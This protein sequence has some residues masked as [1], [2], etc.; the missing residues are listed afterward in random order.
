V[1][2]LKESI[3]GDIENNL[4]DYEKHINSEMKMLNKTLSV[5]KNYDNLRSH[6]KY[7][8][9]KKHCRFIELHIPELLKLIGYD[10][11]YIKI[12]FYDHEDFESDEKDDFYWVI[13]I[14]I[15]KQPARK[16]Q[17]TSSIVYDYI[18]YGSSNL[19][20]KPIDI[21]KKLFKPAT[22]NIDTFEKFLE[23]FKKNDGNMVFPSQLLN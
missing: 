1:K 12:V 22:A 2:S 18:T 23:N 19:Y 7:V 10:A 4:Y 8:A 5:L 17:P 20:E 11:E 16:L 14:S 9:G 13:N 21:C 6:S 15:T 3:L